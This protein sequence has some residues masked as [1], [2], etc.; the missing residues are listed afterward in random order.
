MRILKR[1]K[2]EHM[3]IKM[4]MMKRKKNIKYFENFIRDSREKNA[5]MFIFFKKIRDITLGQIR[6]GSKGKNP[7]IFDPFRL[8]K[9]PFARKKNGFSKEKN[10]TMRLE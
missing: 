4:M 7:R 10:G 8:W 2:F 1:D 9:K 5:I 3:G 6:K